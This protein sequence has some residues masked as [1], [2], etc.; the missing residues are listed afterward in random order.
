MSNKCINLIVKITNRFAHFPLNFPKKAEQK[1]PS[2]DF[3]QNDT[4]F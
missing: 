4:P 1:K 3:G 2:R